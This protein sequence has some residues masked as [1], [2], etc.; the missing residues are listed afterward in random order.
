MRHAKLKPKPFFMTLRNI[1]IIIAV[2]IIFSCTKTDSSNTTNSYNGEDL[3]PGECIIDSII[4]YGDFGFKSKKSLLYIDKTKI[5]N[6]LISPSITVAEID[7][8][9]YVGSNIKKINSPVLRA[10]TL[11]SEVQFTYNLLSMPQRIFLYDDNYS[12]PIQRNLGNYFTYNSDKTIQQFTSKLLDS[13]YLPDSIKLQFKYNSAGLLDSVFYKRY[14]YTP[15]NF[16]FR[17]R[18]NY[19]AQANKLMKMANFLHLSFLNQQV[20]PGLEFNPLD[21]DIASANGQNISS[22]F[23][24]PLIYYIL[25][26]SSKLPDSANV[27]SDYYNSIITVYFKYTFNANGYPIS[28]SIGNN[29]SFDPIA[30][31]KLRFYYKCK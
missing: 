3:N 22:D 29:P 21:F 10:N 11:V 28:I 23:L 26:S 5:E 6:L 14:N 18:F 8:L 1:S 12:N 20:I 7:S 9:V 19:A 17:Y 2:T 16:T 15:Y 4:C 25:F 24:N 30:N 27:Y 13:Y 31:E